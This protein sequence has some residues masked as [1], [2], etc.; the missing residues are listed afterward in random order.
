MKGKPFRKLFDSVTIPNTDR[1]PN[2]KHHRQPLVL[3]PAPTYWPALDPIPWVVL[4]LLERWA[5]SAIWG[6]LHRCC[7]QFWQ[8]KLNIKQIL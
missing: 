3:S 5:D 7:A 6:D 2:I 8:N 1:K 4:V